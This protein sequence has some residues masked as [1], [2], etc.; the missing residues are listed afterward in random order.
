MPQALWSHKTIVC[1]ATNFMSFWLMYG[2]EAVLS[3][4]VKY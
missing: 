1:R 3:E 4:E 2:A